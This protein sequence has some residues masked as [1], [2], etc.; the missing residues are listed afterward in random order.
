M[1]LETDSTGYIPKRRRECMRKTKRKILITGLLVFAMACALCACGG[2]KKDISGTYHASYSMKDT[3][4]KQLAE[5][6]MLLE[7]DVNADFTLQLNTEETFT[8]DIDG[9]SLSKS[10]TDVLTQDGPGMITAMLE[11]EG[12]TE[13]MHDS[14]AAASGYDSYD[15]FVTD[16]VQTI[17][18]EMG[19]EFATDLETQVHYEG[20]YALNKNTLTLTGTVNDQNGMDQGTVNEDGTI[21]ISSKMDDETTL[22]LTF[23]K[24]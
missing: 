4:N 5:S 3:L 7:S 16:M 1:R 9:E 12:V 15:A 2:K 17:V 20:T 23:T 22:D 14:I 21:S 10:L 18:A 11:S 8:I 13:D 6:G 19:D 24:Q